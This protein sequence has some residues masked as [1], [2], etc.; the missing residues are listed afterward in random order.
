M[1]KDKRGIFICRQDLYKYLL[2]TKRCSTCG[3]GVKFKALSRRYAIANSVSSHKIATAGL[4]L[5]LTSEV[6]SIHGGV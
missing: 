1:Q 5:T 3:V 6:C 2:A 4:G